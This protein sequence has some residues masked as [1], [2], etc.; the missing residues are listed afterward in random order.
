MD[1]ASTAGA[2]VVAEEESG[3]EGAGAV[4]YFSNMIF[5]SAG[6]SED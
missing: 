5:S 4:A 6:V 2:E 1:G 3:A